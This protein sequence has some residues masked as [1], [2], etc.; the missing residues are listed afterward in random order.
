MNADRNNRPEARTQDAPAS[1]RPAATPDKTPS[2]DMQPEDTGT[3]ESGNTGTGPA[4]DKAMKQ[5]SKTDAQRG[6][7][8]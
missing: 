3:P 4:A 2:T 6:S 8:G 5:T 7:K 1:A